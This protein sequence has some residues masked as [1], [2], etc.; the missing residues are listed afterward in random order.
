MFQHPDLPLNIVSYQVDWQTSQSRHRAIPWEKKPKGSAW[1]TTKWWPSLPHSDNSSCTQLV[2][3]RGG[4]GF[5]LS[6]VPMSPWCSSTQICLWLTPHF[7]RE[8]LLRKGAPGT[9][10]NWA[11]QREQPSEGSVCGGC[12]TWASSSY[13][14]LDRCFCWWWGFGGFLRVFFGC[15]VFLVLFCFVSFLLAYLTEPTVSFCLEEKCCKLK[16][17]FFHLG[18]NKTVIQTDGLEWVCFSQLVSLTA[19]TVVL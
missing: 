17:R 5:S 1:M 6:P 4:S 18:Y 11:L 10:W 13:L 7:G 19:S 9:G 8:A 14:H 16:I 3:L 15:S 12:S 2:W